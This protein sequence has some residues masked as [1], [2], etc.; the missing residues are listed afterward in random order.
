M[1]IMLLPLSSYSGKILTISTFNDKL[2]IL[3]VFIVLMQIY[4]RF[5]ISYS[6]NVG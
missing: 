2:L 6:S 3:F 1:E 4:D 5:C